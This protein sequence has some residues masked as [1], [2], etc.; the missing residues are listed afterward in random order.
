MASTASSRVKKEA[1]GTESPQTIK[2]ATSKRRD[3]RAAAAV[4]WYG[5]LL[6]SSMLLGAAGWEIFRLILAILTLD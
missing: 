3:R 1:I 2:E 6:I 4:S 5:C